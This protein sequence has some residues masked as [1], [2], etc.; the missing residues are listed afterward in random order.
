VV[1]RYRLRG[2][3]EN[4]VMVFS[5]E[6]PAFRAGAAIPEKFAQIGRNPSPP[7]SGAPARTRG[8]VLTVEDLDATSGTFRHC[9]YDIDFRTTE[10]Q[11]GMAAGEQPQAIN[12]ASHARYDGPTPPKGDGIHHYHFRLA[13]LDVPSLQ[14]ANRSKIAVLWKAAQ[15]HVLAETELVGTFET[16]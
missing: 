11:E 16:N 10:L 1:A 8:L 3:V 12:D 7:L 5:L 2:F 9:V 15:P 6:S 4:V 14:V 13:A